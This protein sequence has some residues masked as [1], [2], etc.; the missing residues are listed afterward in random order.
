MSSDPQAAVNLEFTSA[1][2]QPR[3]LITALDNGGYVL[4]WR[5]AWTADHTEI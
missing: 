1:L 4:S 2:G 3:P 5:G